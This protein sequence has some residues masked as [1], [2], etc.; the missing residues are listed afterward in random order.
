[1][2]E[3]IL[4]LLAVVLAV[5]ACVLAYQATR[6]VALSAPKQIMDALQALSA[7]VLAAEENVALAESK[8]IQWRQQMDGVLEAVEDALDRVDRKRRS[9]AAA[10]AKVRAHQ[11][12]NNASEDPELALVQRA[13]S[14]GIW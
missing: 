2:S 13:R 14:Q 5:S 11:D 12:A 6:Q 9:A 7:R 1:M 8:A 10:A 4:P 3:L